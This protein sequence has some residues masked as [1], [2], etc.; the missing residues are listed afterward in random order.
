MHAV[1]VVSINTSYA[2]VF[3]L[4]GLVGKHYYSRQGT[5][6]FVMSYVKIDTFFVNIEP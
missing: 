6:L 2:E 3:I 4:P 5:V 1:I